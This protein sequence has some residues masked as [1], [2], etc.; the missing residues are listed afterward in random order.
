MDRNSQVTAA[1][2]R[3]QAGRDALSEAGARCMESTEDKAGMVWERWLMPDGTSAVLVATPMWWNVF[4]PI[5]PD[6]TV[7]AT[8]AAI[9]AAAGVTADSAG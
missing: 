2:E 1:Y 3:S 7:D 5:T 6:P 4:T 8:V 9:R